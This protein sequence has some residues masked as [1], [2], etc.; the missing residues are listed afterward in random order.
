MDPPR[1]ER[2]TVKPKVTAVRFVGY[3]MVAEI[4][5]QRVVCPLR[6]RSH[7]GPMQKTRLNQRVICG[8]FFTYFAWSFAL[9]GLTFLCHDKKSLT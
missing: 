5:S 6:H 2:V 4:V 8:E 9:V 7:M 1:Y 3:Y